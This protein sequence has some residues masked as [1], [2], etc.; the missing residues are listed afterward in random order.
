[1]NEEY[2]EQETKILEYNT[3]I[4]EKTPFFFIK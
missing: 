4:K 3:L 1:M 2:V